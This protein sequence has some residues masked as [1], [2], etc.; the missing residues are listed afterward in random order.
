MADMSV[1]DKMKAPD[2]IGETRRPGATGV[3]GRTQEGSFGWLYEKAPIVQGTSGF[4][5]ALMGNAGSGLRNPT[6]PFLAGFADAPL[7]GPFYNYGTMLPAGVWTVGAYA[8]EMGLGG[9]VGMNQILMPE[10]KSGEL[11]Y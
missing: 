4:H 8:A 2:T 5:D 7:I 10:T 9:S 3:P 6:S 1:K 11:L